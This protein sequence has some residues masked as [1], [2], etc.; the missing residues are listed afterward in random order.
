M[1]KRFNTETELINYVTATK[2]AIGYI[3]Q[4]TDTGD[5]KSISVA[6][7]GIP[8]FLFGNVMPDPQA[9]ALF[10]SCGVRVVGYVCV[11]AALR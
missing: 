10:E 11:S 2:G 1:P 6:A 9:F 4:G 8:V 3:N 5:T 7:N